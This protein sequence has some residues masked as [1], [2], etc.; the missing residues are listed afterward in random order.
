MVLFELLL[1]L[2]NKQA[3]FLNSHS[4]LPKLLTVCPVWMVFILEKQKIS[5]KRTILTCNLLC[6]G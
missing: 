5:L 2:V 4:T 3:N 6:V 1:P